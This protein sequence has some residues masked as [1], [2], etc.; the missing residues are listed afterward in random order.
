MQPAIL[1]EIALRQ[2]LAEPCIQTTVCLGNK[3]GPRLLRNEGVLGGVLIML[4]VLII[5]IIL[6]PI[7]GVLSYLAETGMSFNGCLFIVGAVQV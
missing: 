6:L 1:S 2:L 7:L 4:I 3:V 5:L